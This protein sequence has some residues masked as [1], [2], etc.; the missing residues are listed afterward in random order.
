MLETGGGGAGR[1]VLDLSHG[2]VRRGY[3]VTVVYSKGR[4]ERD[5][6]EKLDA[7]PCEALAVPMQRELGVSD[8]VALR[9][10]TMILDQREPFSIVH[11]HSSK[12]GAL[13]RLSTA[14]RQAVRV[15]TPHAFRTLDPALGP[16]GRLAF[17]L[18]ERGLARWR[19][20][21]VIAVSFQEY[22]HALRLG[23]PKQK[24]H[25]VH[26]GVGVPPP[27]SRVALRRRFALE[28]DDVVFGFVGRLCK[29][30]A[31][32]RLVR[33]FAEV[34]RAVPNARLVLLGSGDQADALRNLIIEHELAGRVTLTSD[35]DGWTLMRAFDVFVLPSR[36]EAMPYVLLEA[37]S[38]GLPIIATDVGG[39]SAVVSQLENGVVV[40]NTEEKSSLAAAMVL[41]AKPDV[42]KRMSA[43]AMTRL[44]LFSLERMLDET[45]RVYD[46][47][48]AN[49]RKRQQS[50]PERWPI[51]T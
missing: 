1:H 38:V 41:L 34:I 17:G 15:Y 50:V 8:A 10:V 29:Q 16:V 43:A 20:D 51:S 5:F 3:D 44:P 35:I 27:A 12:A 24:L 46:R 18:I 48:R 6:L 11:A 36:Y 26:N 39:V 37:A 42:R 28:D 9:R 32:E 2:L 45:E 40:A 14:P 31:P 33:A 13:S 23:V 22:T 7:L 19:T 30:K 47:C 49:K 25:M 21:G 4:A